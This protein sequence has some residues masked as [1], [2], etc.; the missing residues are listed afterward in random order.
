MQ[1][2]AYIVLF[3]WPALIGSFLFALIGVAARRPWLVVVAGVLL[4]PFS[5]LLL[6][7]FIPAIILPLLQ[8]AAA[9]GLWRGRFRL[10]W[11]LFGSWVIAM[12]AMLAV[13]AASV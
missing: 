2:T 13:G 5:I 10:A 8:F 11:V 9:F 12:V 7:T 1:D 4:L 6:R 3:G